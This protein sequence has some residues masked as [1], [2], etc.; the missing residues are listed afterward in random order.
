M[1]IPKLQYVFIAYN[2][3]KKSLPKLTNYKQLE[4]IFNT[5]FAS[6]VTKHLKN[7]INR[8]CVLVQE[9]IQTINN[10]LNIKKIVAQYNST[11]KK[12]I[13]IISD[14]LKKSITLFI[15]NNL[16]QQ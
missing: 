10:S 11:D 7:L 15:D 5:T 4:Y 8:L 14:D 16:L 13:R 2:N 1:D 9:I 3:Y 12:I 6:N